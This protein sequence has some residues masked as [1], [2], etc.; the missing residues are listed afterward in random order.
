MKTT[1][2]IFS[3]KILRIIMMSALMALANIMPSEAQE[4]AAS[5]HL[6]Y[7]TD[8][9]DWENIDRT[10]AHGK[11]VTLKTLL[12]G[13]QFTF[14]M[15]GVGVDPA[16]TNAKFAQ[17]TGYMVTS[18][19]TSEYS[20]DVPTAITSPLSSI[21]KLKIVQAS[22]GSNRGL[23][24]S[25]KGDGD[26]D[27]V[28]LHKDPT[29]QGAHE[30]P[31]LAVNRTNC[32]IK[33]ENY[34]VDD[35]TNGRN[36]NA[37]IVDLKIY[38]NVSTRTF[39]DFKVDFR[40][41]PYSVVAPASGLPEGVTITGGSFS[42]NQHGYSNAKMTVQ[43]DGPVRFMIGG[44]SQTDQ[45]TVSVDGGT[46]ITIDTKSIGCDTGTGYSQYAEY[47]YNSDK[48]ALL[49]FDLGKYCP[50]VIA[51]ACEHINNHLEFEKPNGAEGVMPTKVYC[52]NDGY[53]V[54]PEANM[55]SV[56]GYTF[57]AWTDG[58][59]EYQPGEKYIF[60]NEKTVIT[61]KMRKNTCGL[62]DS[63]QQT[64]V[65]WNFDHS[66]APAINIFS[67]NVQNKVAYTYPTSIYIDSEKQETIDVPLAIDAS[68]GKLDNTDSRVQALNGGI[69]GALFTD[70]LKFTIPAIYGMTVTV[71]ASDKSDGAYNNTQTLFGPGTDNARIALEANDTTIGTKDATIT[72]GGKT[73]SFTYKGDDL[74]IT[75]NTEKAGSTENW[76]FVNDITVT[77]PKLPDV[78]YENKI[79][80]DDSDTNTY[81]NETPKNAGSFTVTSDIEEGTIRNVGTRYKPGDILTF[82]AKANYGY[83]FAGFEVNGAMVSGSS[84]KHHVGTGT[85]DIKVVFKRKKLYRV[86]AKSEDAALGSATVSPIV[87]NF[88]SESNDM[89]ECW[90]T[91]GTEVSVTGEASINYMLDYWTAGDGTDKV[92][93]NPYTFTVGTENKTVTAHFIIGRRGNI[94]FKIPD[95]T[96]NGASDKYNG[97]YSITPSSSYNVRSFVIPSNYTFY[98]NKDTNHRGSTLQYWTEE[99]S[100]GANH[101]MPGQVYSFRNTGETITLVPVFAEN[102]AASDNRLN[103]VVVR[104]D[105]G[106]SV[107]K[108]YDPTLKQYRKVCAQ[109]VNIGNN[110]KPFWTAQTYMDV[111][112]EGIE[113]SHNRDI[114]L[115][116]DTGTNGYIRNTD[117]DDWCAF[118]PGTTFWIP[119]GNGTKISMLT[120]SKIT[121]TTF[122]G[123]VPQ[124]DEQRTMQERQRTGKDFIYVYTYTTN[125]TEDRVKIVIGDDYSYYQWI[126]LEILAA[127]MV[128]LYADVDNDLC[129]TVEGIEPV[130]GK[131]MATLEDGGY[132]FRQGDRV[133]MTVSRKFGYELD[134]IVDLDKTDAYGN[135]LTVMKINNDGTIDMVSD[136]DGNNTINVSG[137]NGTWG[138]A[139]GSGK[140]VFV[141]TKTEPTED[142]AANG[143]RTR[144]DIQF[145]ITTHRRLEICFKEKPTYYV[146]YN[147]GQQ[148]SGIAPEA[149]WVEEGD[150]Y[151][152]PANRTLYYEGYTLDHWED[153]A[154]NGYIAGTQYKAGDKD[155][156]LF[157]IFKPNKFSILDITSETTAT[158]YFAKADG[159]PT[160]NY[161]GKGAN[162]ILVTQITKDNNSIDLKIDLDGTNGKFNNTNSDNPERIQIN[163]GSV[164]GFTATPACVAKLVVTDKITS[165]KEDMPVKI[166]GDT[167]SIVNNQE[168]QH[169]C[170]ANTSQLKVEFIGG[171]YCRYFSVT[172]KPQDTPTATIEK[173]TCGDEEFDK[174]SIIQQ[175]TDNGHVTFHISPWLYADERMPE[176][177]GT[178]TAGATVKVTDATLFNKK[179]DATVHTASG[180]VV[181][182][183]P[184]EFEF[185]E[186][187]D[188][189]NP[190]FVKLTV[191]G[192]EYLSPENE[193][194]NVAQNGIVKVTFSRT[195]QAATIKDTKY[196][197]TSSATS[198]KTLEFKYWDLPKGGTVELTISPDMNI[199]KDIY[200]KTCQQTLRL[201]LHVTAGQNYYRHSKFDFIV[202]KD[203]SVDQAIY[204]AN[205]NKK[206]DGQR[207]FIFVPDGEYEL[208]GNENT[209]KYSNESNGMT[210]INKP[211]VSIIGQSKD[212]TLIYNEPVKGGLGITAT[213]FVNKNM[214][215]FYAEDLTIEN[216]FDYWNSSSTDKQA[217]A[218]YDR[219]NRSI[220]KNVA[221]KSWQDTYCSSNANNNFRG[222]FENSDLYGVVDFLCGD[223]DIWLEKCNIIL[224]DRSGNNIAAPATQVGQQWGYVFNQCNIKPET[225]T[226]TLLKDKD[227]TL[228]RPWNDSPACTYINT[229]MYIEPSSYGWTKMTDTG[230][231]IRFHEYKSTN[232]EGY[233]LSLGA[234]SLA[235]C[236]PAPGSDDCILSDTQAA[237]YTKRNIMGGEDAFEP[238]M[239]CRQ[240]DAA[241]GNV[242]DYDENQEIWQDSLWIDDNSLNWKT[243]E[244]AL[245][246]VVFKLNDEGKWIYIDNTTDASLNIS[247]YGTGDYCV[248][249]ANQRGGLGAATK[250]IAYSIQSPFELQIKQT[251][252][253]TVDGM[254]YG[255]STVCLP[256]NAKVPQEL[257]V[258]AATAHYSSNADDK[259]TDYYMT[260]TPV[261]VT[262]SL[263]GY[264]V[265]GPV[266]KYLFYP[267]S[268]TS[269]VPTILEGNATK[270]SISSANINCYVLSNKTMGLGFYKYK[271]ATLA[272]YKAWLPANKVSD[273]INEAL[274]SGQSGIRLVIADTTLSPSISTDDTQEQ[275][276]IY[277]LAGQRIERPTDSGIYIYR[278]K[279]KV[280]KKTKTRP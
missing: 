128:N 45:A 173:L 77:Y 239:L 131:D 20:D 30:I 61:P 129:G 56:N 114:A 214:T 196:N 81:P 97:A 189:N 44:C 107:Q 158:W 41:N 93:S 231:K 121:T 79:I 240:I 181:E 220:M 109:A 249:A 261:D 200:G 73:I 135:P 238:D 274:V 66:E 74:Y 88:Y 19:Y 219:G 123:A 202:G 226:P 208:S 234:R 21:T 247:A 75:L 146:T 117:I 70:H 134:K 34:Y 162:G 137:N 110:E 211:N 228:A 255:W 38:G 279:G 32:Q 167:L 237:S 148:A 142:E 159:A 23:K 17:Y 150:M 33:F 11:V 133:K 243:S 270:V 145:D 60:A 8:F 49:T 191:N 264:I 177:T 59:N 179:C 102:P 266:G 260:L 153:E 63:N 5:E 232:A 126:E 227:Y 244:S 36:Q 27:W 130:S 132:A 207:Y 223:G 51:E 52:D 67:L 29:T 53:A 276:T 253:L 210:V 28:V 259:V 271:G 225:A 213:I 120:Y 175:I 13:E 136:A 106:R 154:G 218:F 245:C 277:N 7:S 156:L 62:Y 4:T 273:G 141:L 224:R 269:M 268:H 92:S 149:E 241:S 193:L 98:R 10:T 201:K 174:A 251:A 262:N 144:Y 217:V 176:V 101:Y 85:D 138:T 209:E 83:D 203:G 195:M 42:S 115:W 12:S 54:M 78:V 105:F 172:Y 87:E 43:A 171:P 163:A 190:T 254:A 119:S 184:I 235:A 6:I 111:L 168:P 216:K 22:T 15:N 39:K 155:L 100:D 14:T 170:T 65:T 2:D 122:D 222:Y 182:T 160:I 68:N 116:C 37:Y 103:D 206:A 57:E 72:D 31:E 58:T 205:H 40:Q 198:A 164:I 84:Y 278:S 25:V 221:L 64:T 99:G 125:S 71:H 165:K 230:L 3:G 82:E 96:V 212:G 48:K 124:L 151:T 192:T 76:G 46:P 113:R 204:A 280:M 166:E 236:A 86:I 143:Q 197:I 9:T 178:A 242:A 152:I 250:A 187:A 169:I 50:Y 183:Y 108:Y 157:P 118:G 90:Y 185:T 127:N 246:Y 95:G 180:I 161:Q 69:K 186:P 257:E 252:G 265:Y 16:G 275:E 112:E 104:Y 215:D 267:T 139:S 263:N 256:F 147:T 89:V 18:K 140:T 1:T 233:P 24:V 47:V 272:P 94:I 199:F 194:Y 55:F 258:Y 35:K 26:A 188:G 80:S 229:R 248:R 91:E